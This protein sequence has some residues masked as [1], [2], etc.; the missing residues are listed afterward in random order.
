MS[1]IDRHVQTGEEGSNGNFNAAK[2]ASQIFD[3]VAAFSA[4]KEGVS[5]PPIL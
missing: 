1:R 4:D 2:E 5:A 3:D